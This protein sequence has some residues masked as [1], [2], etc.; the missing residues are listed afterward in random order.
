MGLKDRLGARRRPSAAYSLRIEDDSPARAELAAARAAGD[1]SRVVAAQE[2]VEACYEQVTLTA[3]PPAE[4]EALIAAHPAPAGV[5]KIFNPRTF[6][7][8][9][10][11]VSVDSDV[12]EEDWAE[13][14]TSGAM[15]NGEIIDLFEAVWQL[16]YRVPDV[17]VKK[18]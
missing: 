10:L 6:M 7:P 4:L 9:L 2:A 15:T 5:N 12:A 13:Y 18:D 8:A 11:A 3:L 14:Y 1:E 17:H 16:N